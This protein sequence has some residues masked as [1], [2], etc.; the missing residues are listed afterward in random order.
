MS[1]GDTLAGP[2]GAVTV[3]VVVPCYNYGHLLPGC[4]QSVLSQEGVATHVLIIDDASPDG[5]GVVARRLA[6][7]DA[8]VETI[9][10]EVNQGHIATYNEG[11][12]KA[13][14]DYVVL[15]SA[16]DLLTPGSLRRATDVMERHPEVGFV[17][18]HSVYFDGTE[19]FP[20]VRSSRPRSRVW[21]GQDWIARRCRSATNVIS[22]PEVVIRT[23]LHHAVG[24]YRS[25]LPH[26]GDLE[27]WLRLASR[28]DVGVVTGVDQ[29]LYR[30]HGAS[31]SRTT[32]AADAEELQ[33]RHKAFEVFFE[34]SGDR[35]RSSQ[36]L[37][38]LARRASARRALWR[39]SR[40]VRRPDPEAVES[41]RKLAEFALNLCPA[42]SSSPEYRAWRWAAAP[43][44][45]AA[46]TYP[47]LVATALRGRAQSWLYWKQ[48]K[49]R[50]V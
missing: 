30:V 23:S 13:D 42:A 45:P 32:F 44:R 8:R 39:A 50:G 5:S 36:A 2:P 29:A 22:S 34:S 14:G 24:G 46:W 10:H 49:W 25:D 19:P 1:A 48:R 38:D 21:S 11:L 33:Q 20:K 9:V 4:V 37:L 28:M 31:M 16:D 41:A 15:L 3:T 18:G 40:L 6:E 47:P 43:D 26:S 35:V 17:Y 27:M 12:D 7:T